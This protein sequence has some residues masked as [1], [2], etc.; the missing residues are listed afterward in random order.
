MADSFTYK[1]HIIDFQTWMHD[2]A[3]NAIVAPEQR[4]WCIL[5][6]TPDPLATSIYKYFDNTS[7]NQAYKTEHDAVNPPD[8]PGKFTNKPV[9]YLQADS[10]ALQ[11]LAKMYVYRHQPRLKN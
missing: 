5:G 6:I 2:T 4:N 7:L 9:A 10:D 1:E 11:G 8:G 3:K